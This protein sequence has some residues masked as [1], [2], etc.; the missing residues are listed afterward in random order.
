MNASIALVAIGL[1]SF[2]LG[3]SLGKRARTAGTHPV[4]TAPQPPPPGADRLPYYRDLL[5]QLPLRERLVAICEFHRDDLID[6]D[7]ACALIDELA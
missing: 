4:G 3:I 5:V 7:T 6:T 2:L 1:G